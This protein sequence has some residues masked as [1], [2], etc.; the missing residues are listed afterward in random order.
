MV[1]NY[2]GL[3][4]VRLCMGKIKAHVAQPSCAVRVI[5]LSGTR[6]RSTKLSKKYP[7]YNAEGTATSQQYNMEKDLGNNPPSPMQSSIIL[8]N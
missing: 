2:L 7:G 1:L 8:G 6:Q 3:P 5:A 4:V